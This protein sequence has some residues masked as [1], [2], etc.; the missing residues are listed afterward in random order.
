MPRH[1]EHLPIFDG[2]SPEM[3]RVAT[4]TSNALD[5]RLV[6]MVAST[7]L[8]MENGLLSVLEAATY[9]MVDERTVY[10][11]MAS[12]AIRTVKRGDRSGHYLI[13]ADVERYA[14]AS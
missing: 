12:G 4:R 7:A 10:R 8:R 14:V 9:L 13:R 2:L 11:L 1:A 5:R 3:R 6:S